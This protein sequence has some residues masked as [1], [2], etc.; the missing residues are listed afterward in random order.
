M[1]SLIVFLSFIILSSAYADVNCKSQSGWSIQ[2]NSGSQPKFT[3]VYQVL[4][5]GQRSDA[6]VLLQQIFVSPANVM[7]RVEL[8][9]QQVEIQA[10]RSGQKEEYAQYSGV[11]KIDRKSQLVECT[12]N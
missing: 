3:E 9:G 5:N 2:F 1:K 10:T 11:L 7:A 6:D 8:D 12:Q 4:K